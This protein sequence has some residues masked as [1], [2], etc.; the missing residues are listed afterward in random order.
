[1]MAVSTIHRLACRACDYSAEEYPGDVLFGADDHGTW[2][3]LGHPCEAEMA[4]TLTGHSLAALQ[5][6]GRLGTSV[7]S[8]CCACGEVV[9]M[10]PRTP[11][12]C[13]KCGSDR[14]RTLA[15][16]GF[17]PGCLGVMGI[18]LGT[19]ALWMSVGVVGAAGGGLALALWIAL[20]RSCERRHAA[21]LAALPCPRCGC[22]GLHEEMTGVS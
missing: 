7:P 2:H 20:W 17:P 16:E 5:L 13:T 22:P 4:R 1:M 11:A 8:L 3:V 15:R 12:R 18:V 14:L 19:Y 9:Y 10:P 6:A 21:Y